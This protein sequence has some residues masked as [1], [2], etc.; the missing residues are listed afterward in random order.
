MAKPNEFTLDTG[1]GELLFKV[2][3][4]TSAPDPAVPDNS[5]KTICQIRV[6]ENYTPK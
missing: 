2:E 6:S 5:H 3:N 4:G 1:M